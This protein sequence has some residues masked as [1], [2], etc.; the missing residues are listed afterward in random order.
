MLHCTGLLDYV[1]CSLRW[2][3]RQQLNYKTAFALFHNIAVFLIPVLT[4]HKTKLNDFTQRE[5]GNVEKS[6]LFSIVYEELK[7]GEPIGS[8]RLKDHCYSR[9]FFS[10]MV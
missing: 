9:A 2:Y 10:G 5:F 8:M 7:T 3:L 4:S 6:F 1:I